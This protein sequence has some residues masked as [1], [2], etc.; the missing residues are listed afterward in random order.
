MTDEAWDLWYDLCKAATPEEHAV[1]L[2]VV[3]RSGRLWHC[4]CG[5]FHIPQATR[6]WKCHKEQRAPLAGLL[7]AMDRGVKGF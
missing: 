1:L 3:V 7:I 4:S 6:C 5:Q 2:E